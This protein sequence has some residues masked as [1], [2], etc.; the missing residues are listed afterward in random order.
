MNQLANE[1]LV[2]IAYDGV[3]EI[4]SILFSL[5][6]DIHNWILD[7]DVDESAV[8][9]LE[10]INTLMEDVFDATLLIGDMTT[11]NS[12]PILRVVK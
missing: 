4:S 10:H 12:R 11:L 1:Q 2:A 3:E 6:E 9:L 5:S 8:S 7:N